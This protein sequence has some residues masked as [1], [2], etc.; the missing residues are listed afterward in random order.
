MQILMNHDGGGGRCG[1]GVLLQVRS[2]K[3][4]KDF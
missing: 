3:G 1:D 2:F 4:F